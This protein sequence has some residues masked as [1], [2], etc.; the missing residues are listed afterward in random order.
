M[1]AA[2]RVGKSSEG[3]IW[4]L[5]STC[6]INRDSHLVVEEDRKVHWIS[7]LY[8]LQRDGMDPVWTNLA[9]PMH[10]CSISLPLSSDGIKNLVGAMRNAFGSNWLS[11]IFVLGKVYTLVVIVSVEEQN[12]P[13]YHTNKFCFIF[14][15]Y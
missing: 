12:I 7:D 1:L 3:N 10:E 4:V 9:K 5:S 13:F 14:V 6:Q 2:S 11:S 8:K 15:L